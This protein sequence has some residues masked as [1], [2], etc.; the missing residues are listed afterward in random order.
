M[1]ETGFPHHSGGVVQVQ[2]SARFGVVPESLLED[3]RLDLD[4]RAVA[5]WLAVKP[6]GWQISIKN[7]RQR[8]ARM[9][10]KILGK[11]RWQRIAHELES[12]GYLFRK[13]INGKDGQWVWHIVFNPVPASGTVAG[14]ASYGLAAHGATA[15]GSAGGGIDG[16]KELPIGELQSKRTT[17][18]NEAL[19]S[20]LFRE[21]Q[22]NVDGHDELDG[23]RELHYPKV[24]P[25]ELNALKKLIL[26]CR[27]E[28]RQDILDEVEGIRKAG[29]IRSGPV[30][31]AKDLID[32]LATGDFSPSAGLSV[33]HERQTRRR[34]ERAVSIA[35]SS[36]FPLSI[37]EEVI[38]KLPPNLATRAREAAAR[39]SHLNEQG[40]QHDR[41]T[42]FCNDAGKCEKN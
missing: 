5:A 12:A 11:D 30:G 37:S 20:N 27:I 38:A 2:H 9:D 29:A 33:R 36:N 22:C 14:F 16:H 10:K 13:K 41:R 8:L 31:L 35:T 21:A 17:T 40:P 4:S 19:N 28:S 15:D 42:G 23:V 7:L 3:N 26:R 25:D 24:R 6:A 34:N 1:S 32:K 39:M 18:K